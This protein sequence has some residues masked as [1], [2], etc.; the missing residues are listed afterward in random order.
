MSDSRDE[1]IA[2]DVWAYG[3][4][5]PGLVV[6]RAEN[7]QAVHRQPGMPRC[8]GSRYPG[9]PGAHKRSARAELPG[10]APATRGDQCGDLGDMGAHPYAPLRRLQNGVQAT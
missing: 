8:P 6:R 9:N 2:L 1:G 3:Q 10:Q 7:A 5:K 4:A